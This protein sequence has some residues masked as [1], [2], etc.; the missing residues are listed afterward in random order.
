MYEDKNGHLGYP[1]QFYLFDIPLAFYKERHR[2]PACRGP[3]EKLG[4]LEEGDFALYVTQRIE[5]NFQG[6]ELLPEWTERT[7]CATG[8]TCARKT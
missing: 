5:M 2:K 1:L 3:G 7:E 8:N 4:Q 6:D